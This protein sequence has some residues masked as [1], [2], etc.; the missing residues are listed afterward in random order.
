M[1]HLF[2][3]KNRIALILSIL[4]LAT[5]CHEKSGDVEASSSETVLPEPQQIEV[6]TVV[7]E[8]SA[9]E[10]VSEPEPPKPDNDWKLDIPDNHQMSGE[11]LAQLHTAVADVD[12]N[13]VVVIKNGFL[14]DEYYKDEQ[15]KDTVFRFASCSKSFSGALIGVAIEQGYISGIDT[16]LSEFLPQ[17]LEDNSSY[18]QEIAIEHLLTHTSGIEWYEWNGGNSFREFTRS[19]NWIEHILGQR[20]V[21]KPGTY[22]SYTTGGSHLLAVVLEKAT[23]KS[24]LE[25][26]RETVFEPLGMDSVQW[27][28]D[29]QGFIDGGNGISMTARDAAKFGQLYLNGGKWHDEQIIPASWVESST[30]TQ[31]AG[32]GGRSGSYGYQWWIRSF[33]GYDAYYA[34]GHG[35][36]FIFV[37]PELELVAVITSRFQDTYAPWPYFTDYILAAYTG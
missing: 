1:Q 6:V 36:Q 7:E 28:A 32:P 5:G 26:G 13:S 11:I 3:I 29:P 35:G 14:I 10:P 12:I 4:I 19:E 25:F 20:M 18:K 15:D 22:F 21:A 23:G 33:G 2:M 17:I 16:K 8:K 31:D 9:P 27:R 37:V 24:A 30:T 34:M